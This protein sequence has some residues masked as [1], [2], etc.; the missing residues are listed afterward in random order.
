MQ[1]P[2]QPVLALSVAGQGILTWAIPLGVFLAVL[3]WYML[4]LRRRHPE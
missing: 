4:L 1:G 2:S 3:I